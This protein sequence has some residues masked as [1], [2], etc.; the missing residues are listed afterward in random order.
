MRLKRK[1]GLLVILL[2]ILCGM[3]LAGTKKGYHKDVYSEHYVPV[4]EVQDELSFS[5]YKEMDWEQILLQKQEY[6]TKKA[7]SEIL[8]FLGL[9]DYIQ[10]P[11]KSENAAL[12]RG[13]W[14]AVY[15]EILAYLDDEK[16]VTTQDLL[17]MDVIES[18]SGC[19][20]VTN[21]GDYPSK[22]GQHFS[23]HGIITDCIC[24]MVNVLELRESVKRKQRYIILISRLSKMEHLL[25]Y[26][27]VQNMRLQWMHR[28]K[29]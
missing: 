27:V 5:I 6:L 29:M 3:L 10:L 19:I 8:E 21:E 15:T 11:E 28:K 17:L 22:F 4:E 2:L 23:Q 16:T 7:A 25:F 26:P 9:K 18:D 24:W 20:L 1:I 13:E 14:N 12:D